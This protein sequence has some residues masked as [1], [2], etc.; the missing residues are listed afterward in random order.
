MQVLYHLALNAG[1]TVNR[2]DLLNDVWQGRIVVD[3][4]LT[5]T[6]SQLRIAFNDNKSKQVIQ[7]VPKKGYRL[8][9]KVQWV[10]ADY[11]PKPANSPNDSMP[12]LKTEAPFS[13]TNQSS[14]NNISKIDTVHQGIDSNNQALYQHQWNRRYWV[15]LIAVIIVALVILNLEYEPNSPIALEAEQ[16]KPLTQN[17]P[18]APQEPLLERRDNVEAN[19]HF[20]RGNYWLMNGKTSEWFFKAEAA[21]KKAIENDP[22]LAPA[23]GRLAYIYARY[24]YHDVYMTRNEAE[25]KAQEAID[26]AL[27]LQPNEENAKLAQAILFTSNMQF[28]QAK[29]ALDSVLNKDEENESAKTNQGS[30]ADVEGAKNITALYLYSEWALAQ[31]DVEAA[32]RFAEQAKNASPLSP[33]VNVNLAMVH[34]WR[35]EFSLALQS[36]HKAISVD[37]KY[38]WAYVWQAKIYQQ[39]NQLE[40]A[41]NAMLACMEIDNG[42]KINSAYLGLLYLQNDEPSQAEH[43]FEHTASLYGDSLDARFWQGAVRFIHENQAPELGMTLLQSLS[44]LDTPLFTLLPNLA[45]AFQVADKQKEGIAFIEARYPELFHSTA[46]V[47]HRNVSA[48][49]A[50]LRLT[51]SSTNQKR[52]LQTQSLKAK[53]KSFMESAFFY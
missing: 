32:L 5:R 46:V 20:S 50:F 16:Q 2:Q 44:L 1:D 53:L 48:A 27:A 39:Q 14:E 6:I 11:I 30:Y 21:L 34:Y 12:T 35:G 10:G 47:N 38:T 4:A 36:A 28:A 18:N 49:Q 17:K 42:S 41:I 45:E 33:W 24:N 51:E 15:S 13:L 23:Y 31:N 25:S 43:W 29:E 9:P 37:P 26:R 3:E 52:Q 22:E 19:Q 8:V 40:N 7:T